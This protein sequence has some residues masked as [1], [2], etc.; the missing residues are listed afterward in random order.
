MNTS[1]LVTATLIVRDE[2]AVL[3]PCLE[4]IQGLVDEIVVV[5]TGSVDESPA[6]ASGFGAR[7]VHHAWRDDFADARNVALDEANGRWIFYIDADERVVERRRPYLETLLSDASEVAFR[8]LLK[9]RLDSTPYREYRLWRNDPRIRFEGVIHEKV[10][11]AI[12]RV[13]DADRRGVG[14]ADI[15]LQHVGYEGDQTAKHRRN[16]P[17]LR[18]QLAA[19]PENLFVWHHLARVLEGL[20]EADEAE[21]VLERAVDVARA[22][23]YTDAVGVLAYADLIRR[24]LQRGA[25]VRLLLAEA[26]TVYPSNCL[27]MYLEGQDLTA[28]G[29]YEDAIDR[30]DRILRFD[31]TQVPADS[32]AYDESLLGELPH[33]G[34]GFALFK[35]GRYAEAAEAYRAA[36]ALAPSNSGYA[37]K[38]KLA[39]AR[40]RQARPPNSLGNRRGAEP[41]TAIESGPPLA[42]SEPTSRSSGS[43][44]NGDLRRQPSDRS[45]AGLYRVAPLGPHKHLVLTYDNGMRDGVG[46]QLHRMYGIYAISRLLGASYFH[47]PLVGVDYQGLAALERNAGD[48]E[49]HDE[50]NDLFQIESDT[51]PA[52]DCHTIHLPSISLAIFHQLAD[53]FDLDKTGGRPSLIRVAMPFGI[54]D[55]FPDCYEVCKDISPFPAP[56]RGSVDR[57]LRVAVHVRR[58]ELLVLDSDRM[59]PNSYYIRVAQQIARVL[60]SRGSDYQVELHTEVPTAEFTVDPEHHG[61]G[62]RIP[63]PVVVS[64][65]T[66]RLDDFSALPNLVHCLNERA[67]DT[68]RQLATA[69][70][71]VMSRSSFSYLGGILNRNGI[72]LYQPFW[73][74]AP[75]SWMTVDPVGR[76]DDIQFGQAVQGL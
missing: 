20:G 35:A 74:Q 41:A 75:S 25:E 62:S 55:R 28:R 4:S 51:V 6:I 64:P 26:R 57:P 71:L 66:Y 10:V 12:H 13:A 46:A 16:L 73:H 70:V 40:S 8:V 76:F 7:V 72:V 67:I 22:K 44:G 18:R 39:E 63:E 21:V 36:A 19:E 68:I 45:Y 1:P 37:V 38:A 33:D 3:G 11:P 24:R 58:G 52:D 59:L 56:A 47:S 53:M 27:L 54:A 61:I 69:D 15:L 49:F 14:L 42:D 43:T 30:Y 65:E 17:L 31:P 60:E 5:D 23:S 32:P 34:R 9:P 2:A 48:P 50:F 29:A